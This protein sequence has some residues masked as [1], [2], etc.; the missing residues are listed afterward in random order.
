MSRRLFNRRSFLQSAAIGLASLNTSCVSKLTY[1]PGPPDTV[2]FRSLRFLMSKVLQIG[3][4]FSIRAALFTVPDLPGK[5]SLRR[6]LDALHAIYAFAPELRLHPDD[7]YRPT[8]VA[9]Y[10]DRVQ[11]RRHR[12][13]DFDVQILDAGTVNIDSLISQSDAGQHSG[14]GNSRTNFFLEIVVQTEATR[15]G[16]LD[17]AECYV[18][19]RPAP[20]GI[21]GFDIQ[22][23]FFYAYNG[24]I[25]VGADPEH[26]GDWEH[27]TVRVN[28]S[29]LWIESV[30][31]ASHATESSWK[32]R[33]FP[34]TASGHPIAYSAY[35]SH[36]NYWRTGK[37][38]RSWHHV[39]VPDDH[40]ADGGPVWHTWNSLRVIGRHDEP[41][42]RQQW[43]KYTGHWGQIATPG[44]P[45]FL[46]GPYGPAFQAWW[47]DD[48]KGNS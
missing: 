9:W 27:V 7:K 43:I 13:H 26:E 16:R 17:V 30:F 15:R 38:S 12:P 36:A 31:Y 48:D 18:H 14:R 33:P 44:A 24:D 20:G 23:W 11:M 42:K 1:L 35:H 25:T 34:Y 29:L 21:A 4:P 41:M 5:R 10:L 28:D 2:K 46:S 40:T 22:Y 47:E 8:S 37:H 19:F 6:R 3:P 45:E 32:S 39:W